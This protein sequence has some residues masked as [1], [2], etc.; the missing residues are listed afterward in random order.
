MSK[1]KG[2]DLVIG[3]RW[4]FVG[5]K[6]KYPEPEEVELVNEGQAGQIRVKFVAGNLAGAMRWVGR[7]FL[8][9]PVNKVDD[10]YAAEEVDRLIAEQACTRIEEH[11]ISTVSTALAG[12]DDLL[13]CFR[14]NTCCDANRLAELLDMPVKEITGVHLAKRNLQ[15]GLWFLPGQHQLYLARRLAA[16]YPTVVHDCAITDYDR[17]AKRWHLDMESPIPTYYTAAYLLVCSWCHIAPDCN[18]LSLAR[19][20]EEEIAFLWSELIETIDK[21]AKH[22]PQSAGATRIGIRNRYGWPKRWPLTP[23]WPGLPNTVNDPY[24]AYPG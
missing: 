24:N 7:Q 22:S 17:Y 23:E 5:P 10:V 15:T 11:A 21:L 9:A 16:K 18:R 3:D 13:D 2:F 19:G 6:N 14:A 1:R 8:Y 20:Q 4:L 12:E